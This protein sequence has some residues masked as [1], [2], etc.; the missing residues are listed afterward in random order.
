MF[1]T[2]QF[3]DLTQ[4]VITKEEIELNLK[5]VLTAMLMS[6]GVVG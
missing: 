5:G 3:R 6:G 4:H 2:R 1:Q